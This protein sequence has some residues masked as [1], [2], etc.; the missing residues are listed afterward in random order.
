MH[1]MS[2]AMGVL[3]LVEDA[4]REQRFERVRTVFL[5][6][7][8]LAA[9]EP[10]AM[11]F[12]FDAVMSGTLADGS[13][14]AQSAYITADGDWPL[15]VSMYVGKGSVM[16]WL[17]FTN[18]ANSD[19][20]G[21]LVWIKQSGASATS[22]PAGFTIGTKAVGSA[23][24]M[25]LDLGKAL[26]LSGAVVGFSGGNLPAAFNNVVS[27][28]AGGQVVNLSPNTMSFRITKNSGLFTGEVQ[29]PTSNQTFTF[30]GVVLQKQNA[31]YGT[32]NGSSLAS[33][34]VL[35]AP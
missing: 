7:G 13:K 17:T 1:E 29:D 26:N 4:A 19:V 16:S 14:Y 10:E 5:E 15:Y 22:Y 8:E 2:L 21:N 34:V 12:C 28:N 35:A 23:Y 18:L 3:Q 6:I 25:P 30:N 32:M 9:V 20:S 24:V 33:R 27:I 31:G 11:R